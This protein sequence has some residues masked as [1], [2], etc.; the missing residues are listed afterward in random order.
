[1]SPF[2]YAEAEQIVQDWVELAIGLTKE[3]LRTLDMLIL[4]QEGSRKPKT[5]DRMAA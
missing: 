4:M 3:E 2:D 1:M 5:A